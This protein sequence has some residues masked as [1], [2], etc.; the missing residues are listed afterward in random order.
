MENKIVI[1]INSAEVLEEFL[2]GNSDVALDIKQKAVTE[3]VK[4]SFSKVI[5]QE[6][7]TLIR[8]QLTTQFLDYD[9]KK[10]YRPIFKKEYRDLVYDLLEETVS[11]VINYDKDQLKKEVESEFKDLKKEINKLKNDTSTNLK[12]LINKTESDLK[13]RIDNALMNKTDELFDERVTIIATDK[14]KKI[15]SEIENKL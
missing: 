3:I 14:L 11:K 12:Q 6:E 15:Y 7:R 1:Q 13:N 10:H 9:Y 2:K 4:N 5:S 8:E